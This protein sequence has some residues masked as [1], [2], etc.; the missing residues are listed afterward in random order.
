MNKKLKNF[1]LLAGL[2]IISFL[3]LQI[4]SL[5][6]GGTTWDERS[7]DNANILTYEK[8]EIVSNF[9]FFSNNSLNPSL[10]KI[11]VL[12]RMGN[13]FLFNNFF[14]REHFMILNLLKTIFQTIICIQ[15]FIQKFLI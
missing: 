2:I 13:L 3:I 5:K 8:L 6:V 1:N 10:T 11:Q 4:N 14:F 9:D 7:M 15:V 12:R